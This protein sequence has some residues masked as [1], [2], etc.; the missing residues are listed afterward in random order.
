MIMGK[1]GLIRDI[2]H[3]SLKINK[4]KF[5]TRSRVQP[6]INQL[7]FYLRF[8]LVTC[9]G[10]SKSSRCSLTFENGC[11]YVISAAMGPCKLQGVDNLIPLTGE[12][13]RI[14]SP[15]HPNAYPP[16]MTCT[17]MIT[18][19]EGRFA[20]LSIKSFNLE[21]TCDGPVLEIRDGPSLSSKLLK[22]FCGRHFLP[23]VFAS[24]NQ[25][26][27]R[28]QTPSDKHLRGSGFDASF[29]AVTQRKTMM[30]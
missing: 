9:N 28:F 26:W 24:G 8:S 25:L 4:P 11:N 3:V 1:I 7:L 21:K 10:M 2:F 20:Q 27:I 5:I 6:Y 19:P 13:G 18:V 12:T 30:F 14:Y 15:L 23:S 16:N 22:S 17:W 29:K